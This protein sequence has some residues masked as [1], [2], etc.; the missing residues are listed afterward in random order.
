MGCVAPGKKKINCRCTNYFHDFATHVDID[1]VIDIPLFCSQI[2]GKVYF[3]HVENATEFV[4]EMESILY[5]NGAVIVNDC[6][7][8]A[9]CQCDTSSALVNFRK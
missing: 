9:A 3:M 5:E 1:I 7:N 6:T 8:R 2:I 4:L